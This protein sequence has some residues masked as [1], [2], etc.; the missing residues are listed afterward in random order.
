[1]DLAR[2]KPQQRVIGGRGE[3]PRTRI[4]ASGDEEGRVQVTS[5][6]SDLI[7]DRLDDAS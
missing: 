1:M 6:L 3:H 5:K 2:P 7:R 4:P